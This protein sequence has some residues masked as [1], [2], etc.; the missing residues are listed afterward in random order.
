MFIPRLSLFATIVSR[1]Y[2]RPRLRRTTLKSGV[3]H[4]Q[5]ENPMMT[6]IIFFTAGNT[7]MLSCSASNISL[8]S[9]VLHMSD[10]LFKELSDDTLVNLIFQRH[11]KPTLQE[12]LVFCS[13]VHNYDS[14]VQLLSCKPPVLKLYPLACYFFVSCSV[15]VP[16]P[17]TK[18]QKSQ[19]TN[20]GNDVYRRK[21]YQAKGENLK[22]NVKQTNTEEF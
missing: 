8:T 9:N 22:L 2:N 10:I 13:D 12:F 1:L 5:I 11:P 16:P 4:K 21:R 19:T 17:F 6:I 20:K 7:T 18:L 14:W 3:P 15:L